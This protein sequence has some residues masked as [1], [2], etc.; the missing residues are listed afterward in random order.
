MYEDDYKAKL[1]MVEHACSDKN[2][3]KFYLLV[4]R[5]YKSAQ[6]GGEGWCAHKPTR[7]HTCHNQGYGMSV[8]LF[9]TDGLGHGEL[10]AAANMAMAVLDP[11]HDLDASGAEQIVMELSQQC[12][13]FCFDFITEFLNTECD[14][15]FNVAMPVVSPIGFG[16]SCNC[17]LGTREL[18]SLNKG[19]VSHL[20][21]TNMA[22]GHT[23]PKLS[24]E[25]CGRGQG[26][27]VN[28]GSTGVDMCEHVDENEGDG[29]TDFHVSLAAEED[30]EDEDVDEFRPVR[31]KR[32]APPTSKR[33][34]T[35]ADPQPS[36]QGGHEL[37]GLQELMQTTSTM[38]RFNF[39]A[40]HRATDLT[41]LDDMS[42]LFM[43]AERGRF[44][45]DG[46]LFSLSH[47]LQRRQATL[48]ER[49]FDSLS[50]QRHLRDNV[51][52]CYQLL[53]EQDDD[54]AFRPV[55][56]VDRSGEIWESTLCLNSTLYAFETENP[57]WHAEF[58]QWKSVQRDDGEGGEDG[59][60]GVYTN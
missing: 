41:T 54:A 20:Q 12:C 42:F 34:R 25:E 6:Q 18:F 17:L 19:M 53:C 52:V 46:E 51:H 4:H 40:F 58:L 1:F 47:V 21:Q 33:Q 45:V 8:K 60:D 55:F 50:I 32:P 56:N 28:V 15:P 48:T 39:L 59:G 26:R 23:Y 13:G 35:F 29:T 3:E 2:L 30:E 57:G 9:L 31:S 24:V 11:N 16:L 44:C 22:T 5:R 36:T 27:F 38:S 10:V 43:M 14:F 37:V 49:Y 7:C